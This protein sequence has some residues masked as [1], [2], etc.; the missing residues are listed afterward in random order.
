MP[1]PFKDDHQPDLSYVEAAAKSL[2][3]ELKQGDLVILE[4]TLLV[5]TTEQMAQWLAQARRDLS[6][7][8]KVGEAADVN[9]AYLSRA[10]TALA[11]DG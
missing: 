5:G 9:I 1:T 8:Q 7:P 6:F 4:S 2:A 11:S 3:P 10:C